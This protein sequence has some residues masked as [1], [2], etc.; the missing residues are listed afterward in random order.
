MKQYIKP[1]A[2]IV[3]V[4]SR[5][6]LLSGSNLYM[7]VNTNETHTAAESYSREGGSYWDD[8]E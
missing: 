2:I 1:K 7:N 5:H 8:E 4:K 3:N 6:H